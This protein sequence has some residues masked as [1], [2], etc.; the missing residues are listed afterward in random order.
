VSRLY[1]RLRPLLPAQLPQLW[2]AVP[3]DRI[4][5]GVV[6]DGHGRQV[7]QQSRAFGEHSSPLKNMSEL[8]GAIRGRSR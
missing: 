1:R 3:A 6:R 5:S 7:V 8:P 4:V 2:R